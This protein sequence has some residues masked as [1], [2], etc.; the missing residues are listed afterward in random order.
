MLLSIPIKHHLSIV[1]ISISIAFCRDQLHSAVGL[2]RYFIFEVLREMEGEVGRVKK[3]GN[4]D[5]K[6]FFH[7]ILRIYFSYN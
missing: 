2:Q 4:G 3:G 7:F 5:Y 1:D 6:S